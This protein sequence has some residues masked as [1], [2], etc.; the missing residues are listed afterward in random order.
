MVYSVRHTQPEARWL[1]AMLVFSIEIRPLGRGAG[2]ELSAEVGIERCK[3]EISIQAKM[4]IAWIIL[5]GMFL[6][7]EAFFVW[8]SK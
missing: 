1:G 6:S 4:Q 7:K 2:T 3:Q 8:W 5:Q